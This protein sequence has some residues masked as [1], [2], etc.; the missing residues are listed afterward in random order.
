MK[1][2]ELDKLRALHEA[3]TPGPWK[4]TGTDPAEGYDCWWLT[5]C[6]IPNGETEIGS[7][8]GG[9]PHAKREATAQLIVA[10]RNTLPD[11]IA[12]A[13]RVNALEAAMEQ[14][15]IKS[16]GDW[17]EARLDPNKTLDE[18]H[19]LA[20]DAYYALEQ[21]GADHAR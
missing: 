1:Q 14:V 7:I 4:A 17:R 9:Y 21:T 11:L 15:C 20:V 5:A 10:L 6:P 19:T 8:G 12:Q 13:E 3:A 18:I 2:D 16:N